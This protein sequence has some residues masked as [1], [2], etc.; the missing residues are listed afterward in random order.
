MDFGRA[1]A[2]GITARF[3]LALVGVRFTPSEQAGY[4]K[5]NDQAKKLR[6]RLLGLG[7]PDHAF[8][9]FMRVVAEWSE[10]GDWTQC[11][12]A[13]QYLSA[14]GRRRDVLANSRQK[15]QAVAGLVDA[16]RAAN[17][18]LLF[19][20]TKDS[21]EQIA[22]DLVAHGI[23]ADALHSDLLRPE[24]QR[25]LASFATH[26]LR[27]LSAPLVLDEGVDVPEADLAV[28]LAA[29]RTKRQMI[30]R[31]GRVLRRKQD[32]RLARLVLFYVQ[33][34]SEDP[35]T[36]AHEAFLD[37]ALPFAEDCEDFGVG[38]D[39]N[40][41]C[42]YLNQLQPSRHAEPVAAAKRRRSQPSLQ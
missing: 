34:T 28:I 35:A 41:I 4:D 33:G 19:T 37:L 1:T 15:A 38:A 42:R 3:K 7:A 2:D 30:Q 31:M 11:I 14:F 21:A 40:S 10:G 29:S 36:G 5:A 6:T 24:R 16:I 23:N 32:G 12:A 18:T 27:A 22:D 25:L 17:G 26:R 8:G 20:M 13:R 39:P 9:E